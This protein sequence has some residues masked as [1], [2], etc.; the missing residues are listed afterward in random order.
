MFYIVCDDSKDNI[1]II[2]HNKRRIPFR[3]T[4]DFHF[5][6]LHCYE[7]TSYEQARE[8]YTIKAFLK[9]QIVNATKEYPQFYRCENNNFIWNVCI[10]AGG[11]WLN[12]YK[13]YSSQF[14]YNYWIERFS[15]FLNN[16]CA[17]NLPIYMRMMRIGCNVAG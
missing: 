16:E 5:F 9:F 13:C 14:L 11:I 7:T 4:I 10:V 3:N 12:W 2:F 6:I 15:I 1:I 8:M 17:N